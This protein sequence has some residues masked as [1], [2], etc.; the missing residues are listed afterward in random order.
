MGRPACSSCCK[1]SIPVNRVGCVD[2]HY[3]AY[4]KVGGGQWKTVDEYNDYLR[5][6][7]V[8]IDVGVK[9]NYP[10]GSEDVYIVDEIIEEPQEPT[11]VEL[12]ELVDVGSPREIVVNISEVKPLKRESGF[13]DL[14]AIKYVSSKSDSGEYRS[15]ISCWNFPQIFGDGSGNQQFK[16]GDPDCGIH[17][18]ALWTVTIG[19]GNEEIVVTKQLRGHSNESQF[20]PGNLL[21]R[22]LHDPFPKG[23]PWRQW[24]DWSTYINESTWTANPPLQPSNFSIE[25]TIYSAVWTQDIRHNGN[26]IFDKSSLIPYKV[27]HR[28][29]NFGSLTTAAVFTDNILS[30][31]VGPGRGFYKKPYPEWAAVYNFVGSSHPHVPWRNWWRTAYQNFD[32]CLT[33][34]FFKFSSS[35]SLREQ[36]NLY[37][38]D[39]IAG[40]NT[41][42]FDTGVNCNTARDIKDRDVQF[43]H[44]GKKLFTK[45][46]VESTNFRVFNPYS[47]AGPEGLGREVTSAELAEYEGKDVLR[48]GSVVIHKGE[49]LKKQDELVSTPFFQYTDNKIRLT[50]DIPQTIVTQNE[51]LGGIVDFPTG[52]PGVGQPGGGSVERFQ[53]CTGEQTWRNKYGTGAKYLFNPQTGREE[54]TTLDHQ[55]PDNNDL[56]FVSFRTNRSANESGIDIEEDMEV[57]HPVGSDDPDDKYTIKEILETGPDLKPTKVRIEKIRLSSAKV[58]DVSDIELLQDMFQYIMSKGVYNLQ[59]S[60]LKSLGGDFYNPF[61]YRVTRIDVTNPDIDIDCIGDEIAGHPNMVDI[62][63]GVNV[64]YPIGLDAN[65]NPV[66]SD[67]YTIAEIID[68]EPDGQGGTRPIKVKL[69]NGPQPHISPEVDVSDIELINPN[70]NPTYIKITQDHSWSDVINVKDRNTIGSGGQGAGRWFCIENKADRYRCSEEDKEKESLSWNLSE[71]SPA[72]LKRVEG[73]VPLSLMKLKNDVV[74]STKVFFDRRRK[75]DY[76][77]GTSR[78]SQKGYYERDQ[79][80]AGYDAEH[81]EEEN[82]QISFNNQY[83]FGRAVAPGGSND[84]TKIKN[85][86]GVFWE[87]HPRYAYPST[88]YKVSLDFDIRQLPESGYLFGGDLNLVFYLQEID[89]WKR[90]QI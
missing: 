11:K 18:P 29:H 89:E 17:M 78:D 56:I 49:T 52:W 38:W 48:D 77:V 32:F 24:S 2:D 41:H 76:N 54:R 33:F 45:I 46:S 13:R 43:Y 47:N 27:E 8:D 39:F 16:S 44:A 84:V 53:F 83:Y 90:E 64:L 30:I 60:Y 6:T 75:L 86:Y 4:Y 51:S 31:E 85:T 62:E 81:P 26:K 21:P 70:E 7:P 55:Y 10:I 74:V 34:P 40:G 67:E 63:A 5:N 35:D 59:L 12:T 19:S 3:K 82:W 15:E 71:G 42:Y 36:S 25:E 69:S 23:H 57:Y 37:Q 22:Y 14:K 65:G 66:V 20:G 87:P 58:V 61:K 50:S 79:V 28:L 72:T 68:S 9:V 80:F 1:V 88:K 73:P